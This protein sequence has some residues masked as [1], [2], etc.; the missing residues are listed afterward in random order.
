[1]SVDDVDLQ[2][3]HAIHCAA[4]IPLLCDTDASF[5]NGLGILNERGMAK[6]TTYLLDK[7]GT[8]R[9][10]FENVNVDGH[11]DQVLDAVKGLA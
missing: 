6:R 3:E 7:S 9:E 8:V 5:T 11:V 2:K 1:V 4:N 10:V